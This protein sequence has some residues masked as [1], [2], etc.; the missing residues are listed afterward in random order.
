MLANTLVPVALSKRS[1]KRVIIFCTA[2]AFMSTALTMHYLVSDFAL[3]GASADGP[4]LARNER[5]F[6][7]SKA[8]LQGVQTDISGAVTGVIRI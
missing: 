5:D 4:T 6:R 7:S 8:H 1:F 3:D 2:S